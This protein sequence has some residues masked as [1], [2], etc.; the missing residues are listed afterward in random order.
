MEPGSNR[1]F[2][3]VPAVADEGGRH[4]VFE[5]VVHCGVVC[6]PAEENCRD[7]FAYALFLTLV[8]RFAFPRVEGARGGGARAVDDGIVQPR[9]VRAVWWNE[10]AIP[11]ARVVR[12][13]PVRLDRP[14]EVVL[15]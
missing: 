12:V 4:V 1:P 9:R 8:E 3:R 14:L 10:R 6:L 13:G 15:P 11:V 5:V 2:P 7:D